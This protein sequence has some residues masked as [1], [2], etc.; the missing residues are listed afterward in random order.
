MG[1]KTEKVMEPKFLLHIGANKA[2]TS[3]VQ[4]MLVTNPTT[5]G[6]RCNC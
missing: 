2:G 5:H 4:S 6:R 1:D 3:S